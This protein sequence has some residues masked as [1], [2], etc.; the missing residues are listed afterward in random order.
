[1]C[2]QDTFLC[3]RLEILNLNILHSIL[4]IKIYDEAIK[5]S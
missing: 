2:N 3:G 4:V 1:M 5:D